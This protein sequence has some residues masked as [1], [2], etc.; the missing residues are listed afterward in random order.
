MPPCIPGSGVRTNVSG[1]SR[2]WSRRFALRVWPR[3]CMDV[4]PL[5]L[6]CAGR[7][8]CEHRSIIAQAS[9]ELHSGGEGGFNICWQD[10]LVGIVAEA[11]GSAQEKRS[12]EHTSEL[13]S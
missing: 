13:Q 2:R 1:V 9:Q 6:R 3:L 7:N 12:E 4:F 10:G 5:S 11:A 8:S